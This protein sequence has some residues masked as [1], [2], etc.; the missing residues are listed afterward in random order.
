[1]CNWILKKLYQKDFCKPTFISLQEFFTRFLRAS[2]LQTFL[3]TN[4][5]LNVSD[6]FS[7]N[8]LNVDVACCPRTVHNC[9]WVIFLPYNIDLQFTIF[10]I[11]DQ[12]TGILFFRVLY[13]VSNN[14]KI[15]V[16]HVHVYQL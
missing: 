2:L 13:L 11:T 15:W 1:M 16:K 5:S 7:P 12:Y 9:T 3:T 10:H 8:Y 6:I 4:L 14:H